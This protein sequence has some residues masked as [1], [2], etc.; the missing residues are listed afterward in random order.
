MRARGAQKGGREVGDVDSWASAGSGCERLAGWQS[1]EGS[2]VWRSRRSRP[3]APLPAH[4]PLFPAPCALPS[5]APTLLTGAGQGE[6]GRRL[7]WHQ[8]AAGGSPM[9][10]VL[11]SGAAAPSRQDAVPPS[12]SLP[13]FP[14]RCRCATTRPTS[15]ACS[16]A[17]APRCGQAGGQ[18][19]MEL[20]VQCCLARACVHANRC[21]TAFASAPQ[22][23]RGCCLALPAAHRRHLLGPAPACVPHRSGSPSSLSCS[24]CGWA[25]SSPRRQAHHAP[26]WSC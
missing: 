12:L 25:A 24:S 16:T 2:S 7:A 10:G 6:A 11:W 23:P 17:R 22:L 19:V 13:S 18:G 14:R 9:L 15:P 1:A 3:A 20:R 4:P 5:C 26:F 21:P 8:G